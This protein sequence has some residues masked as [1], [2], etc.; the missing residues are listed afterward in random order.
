MM[1]IY[2][3]FV[4][5]AHIADVNAIASL[6]EVAICWGKHPQ[7]VRQA[8]RSDRLVARQL[9]HEWVISIDSVIALWGEPVKEVD[10]VQRMDQLAGSD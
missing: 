5:M 10:Y 4:S 7:T 8:I 6:Q 3:S 2:P 1:M 9:G